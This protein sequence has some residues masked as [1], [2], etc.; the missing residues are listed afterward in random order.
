VTLVIVGS[1]GSVGQRLVARLQRE[2]PILVDRAGGAG[3]LAV[4]LADWEMVASLAD[5][6]PHGLRIIYL[7]AN[8]DERLEGEAVR[9]SL[10]DNAVSPATLVTALGERVDA[11]VYLSSVSVYGSTPARAIAEDYPARPTSLY[12]TGKL[13]A[14]SSLRVL[15]DTLGFSLS[16]L[17]ATQ[18]FAL[19]SA[20]TTLP[21]RLVDTLSA[22]VHPQITCD[23][24]VIRDYLHV[25]DLVD[26]LSTCW[27]SDVSGVFNVGSAAAISIEDLFRSAF[28]AFG[29]T[30]RVDEFLAA[31]L[32]D[33]PS[34]ILDSS[35][36]RRTF[37]YAPARDIRA[38]LRAVAVG[39]T[40]AV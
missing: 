30:F 11:L 17:R 31:E 4:D 23:P 5:E 39:H 15:A 7:A 38:W 35:R 34:Q 33:V 12:G 32:R 40:Y 36:A 29:H 19:S 27:Q 37:G 1:S 24:S 3:T 16:V 25:D 10:L 22:G 20:S 13:A 8:L 2:A 26:L 18:L 9:D 28:E 14:E 21:H 6:L